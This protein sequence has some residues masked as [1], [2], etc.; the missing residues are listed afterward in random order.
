MAS[1][2]VALLIPP[3]HTATRAKTKNTFIFTAFQ[4]GKMQIL[5]RQSRDESNCDQPVICDLFIEFRRGLNNPGKE[6]T[7]DLMI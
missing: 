4:F 6:S 3:T 1:G 5:E 2:M 7:C